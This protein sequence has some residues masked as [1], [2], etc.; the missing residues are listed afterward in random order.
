MFSPCQNL[1]TVY[2]QSSLFGVVLIFWASTL[3]SIQCQAALFDGS[4]PGPPGYIHAKTS[5]VC[6]LRHQTNIRERNCTT[7]TKR[8]R[9]WLY[10]AGTGFQPLLDGL[11]SPGVDFFLAMSQPLQ[12]L[13]NFEILY[14][15][16]V[17][18]DDLSECTNTRALQWCLRQYTGIGHNLVQIFAYGETLRKNGIIPN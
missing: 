8:A 14:W 6:K 9:P 12:A 1:T 2:S 3:K 17:A 16:D 5:G 13:K 7:E 18:R 4:D 15:M 11:A 10:Q